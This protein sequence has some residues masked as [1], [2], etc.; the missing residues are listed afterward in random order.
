MSAMR[1]FRVAVAWLWLGVANLDPS[2]PV[3]ITQLG[4]GARRDPAAPPQHR[5]REC[6]AGR[7]GC[8]CGSKL[9][10]RPLRV[11]RDMY[12]DGDLEGRWVTYAELAAARGIDRQ[13]AARC[14]PRRLTT[15]PHAAEART[16][17]VRE[18][19]LINRL[20]HQTVDFLLQIA[21]QYITT[22]E[23][24]LPCGE[25]ESRHFDRWSDRPRARR[26]ERQHIV[27][28]NEPALRCRRLGAFSRFSH[29]AVR[30][31]SLL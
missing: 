26:G 6:T 18:R 7:T 13:S 31:T 25:A 14:H 2:G 29:T 20:V 17:S 28:D 4:D 1:D 21:C 9:S 3:V 23:N 12:G 22:G 11:R 30:Q 5:P 10:A 19:R 16:I 8:C 15:L 27:L 24:V